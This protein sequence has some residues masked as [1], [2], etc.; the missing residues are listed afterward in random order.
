MGAENEVDKAITLLYLFDIGLFLHHA[1]ADRDLHSLAV[2]FEMSGPSEPAEDTL[3]GVVPDCTGVINKKISVFRRCLFKT[4]TPE[5]T[6][7]LLRI[8][9]VHLTSES[10][11][12]AGEFPAGSLGAALYDFPGPGQKPG[13]TGGFDFGGG[14]VQIRFKDQLLKSFIYSHIF[15]QIYVSILHC[16]VRRITSPA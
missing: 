13:L 14:T 9:G 10:L 3:V 12:A 4:G 6:D 8:P 15:L 2:L 7:D 16:T 1:A 5:N 11:D